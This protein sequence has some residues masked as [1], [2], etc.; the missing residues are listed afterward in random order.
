MSAAFKITNARR[1][2]K[3]SPI[4]KFDLKVPSGLVVRGVRQFEKA[5]KR[6]VGFPSKEWIKSDGIQSY[7]PSLEFSSRDAAD[8]F[9]ALALPLAEQALGLAS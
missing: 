3:N 1:I 8:R 7:S 6:C 9:Q 2:D 4:G 5:G